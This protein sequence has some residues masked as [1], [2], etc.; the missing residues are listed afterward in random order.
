MGI[1]FMG[2]DQKGFLDFLTL[3]EDQ[4]HDSD[5]SPKK[6]KQIIRKKKKKKKKRGQESR[7]LV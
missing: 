3:I 2:S 4:R 5:S 6:E 1:S 7:M